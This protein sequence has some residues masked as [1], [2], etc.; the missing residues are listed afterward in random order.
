MAYNLL[1][2]RKFPGRFLFFSQKP[3]DKSAQTD[4]TVYTT[5]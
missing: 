1:S 2:P 3:L 5:H 4:Y